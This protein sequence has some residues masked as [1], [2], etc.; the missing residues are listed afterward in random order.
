MRTYDLIVFDKDGTLL[1]TSAGIY[2]TNRATLTEMGLPVPPPEILKGIMGPPLEYCFRDVCNVPEDRV[3]EAVRRYINIYSRTGIHNMKPYP[4]MIDVLKDLR[5][6][7]YKLGVATLKEHIFVKQILTENGMIPYIDTFFG[8]SHEDSGLCTTKAAL[9]TRCMKACGC[10]PERTL[11]IGDSRY[12]G[13]GAAE[14]GVDFL[15]VTYGF[16]IHSAADLEGIPYVGIVSD[17]AG[18]SEF[19]IKTEKE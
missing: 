9:I 14:A 13:E 16:S 19:L 17:T 11:M 5:S 7:G 12:D 2:A 8:S 4:G 10:L 3:D 6:N 18:I 15:A 1:D